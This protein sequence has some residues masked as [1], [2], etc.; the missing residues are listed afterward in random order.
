MPF[1]VPLPLRRVQATI[2]GA[3]ETE[4]ESMRIFGRT[5]TASGKQAKA[6]SGTKRLLTTAAAV[7]VA[8]A[9]VAVG[10]LAAL[11]AGSGVRA[12]DASVY[13]AKAA[14][15]Y[16]TIPD[17]LGLAADEAAGA[18]AGKP[19]TY[20]GTTTVGYGGIIGYEQ[21]LSVSLPGTVTLSDAKGWSHDIEATTSAQIVTRANQDNVLAGGEENAQ[22]SVEADP[23]LWSG[24]AEFSISVEGTPGPTAFAVFSNDDE[25]LSMYKRMVPPKEGSTYSVSG[26]KADGVYTNFERA[27][28]YESESSVPWQAWKAQMDHVEVIDGDGDDPKIAVE[29]M[30][31]WFKGCGSI[32]YVTGLEKLDVSGMTGMSRTFQGCASLTQISGM[33]GWNTKSLTTLYRTFSDCVAL[34]SLDLTGWDVT[35]VYSLY[36]TFYNCYSL[37]SVGDLSAWNTHL[38]RDASCAFYNCA[39]LDSIGDIS[40]WRVKRVGEAQGMFQ[41][42]YALTTLGD[43]SSWDTSALENASYMF[44]ACC[45][46]TDIGSLS[47]WN[48]DHLSNASNMFYCCENLTS[49]DLSG[50]S[51]KSCAN[52]SGMFRDDSSLASVGDISRWQTG[53]ITSSEYAFYNCRSLVDLGDLSGWDMGANKTARSMFHNCVEL[54][55]VGTLANW[56]C[57]ACETFEDMFNTCVKLD[58][59]DLRAWSTGAAAS[60][61]SM[62][63][64][65]RALTSTGDLDNWDMTADADASRMFYNCKALANVGDL[66][67]WMTPACTTFYRTFS[68]CAVLRSVGDLSGWDTSA[69]T[70]FD[71]F[72]QGCNKLDGL[73]NL[74]GWQTGSVRNMHSMFDGC[75]ELS[76]I[77]AADGSGGIGSWNLSSCTDLGSMFY[78]CYVIDAIGDLT[79]WDVSKVTDFGGMFFGC[80]NLP[81]L[82]DLSS[83]QV[84]AH[85]GSLE[86]QRM[87]CLCKKL[88]SIGH[89]EGW[90]VSKATSLNRLFGDCREITELGNLSQWDV[91]NC[92]NLTR[93]FS[94]CF[95][96]EDIGDISGW[97]TAKV[98]TMEWLFSGCYKLKAECV[99]GIGAWNVA[100][101]ENMEQMFDECDQL[102]ELDLSGWGASG[103]TPSLRNAA[104]MFWGNSNLAVLDISALDT[105]NVYAGQVDEWTTYSGMA[106]MFG[107]MP[108][109]EK[110]TLGD[111]FSFTGDGSS[112]CT[113]PGEYWKNTAGTILAVDAIP[114]HVADTYTKCAVQRTVAYEW[115]GSGAEASGWSCTATR[116]TKIDGA[117]H[118]D[119]EPTLTVDGAV[120]RTDDGSD[121]S[122]AVMEAV[123][124]EDWASTQVRR[125]LTGSVTID[126]VTPQAV[127]TLTATAAMPSDSTPSYRWYR[128]GAAIAGA[129][130]ST[131]TTTGDD[132]G[133]ALSVVVS[134]SSGRYVGSI[135]SSASASVA[136]KTW[137][138][139][140]VTITGGSSVGSTLTASVS[141]LP[142]S[143]ENTIK[144]QWY[145]RDSFASESTPFTVISGATSSTYKTASAD[146]GY[147]IRCIVTVANTCYDVNSATSNVIGCDYTS[148]G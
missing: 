104:K 85:G 111:A 62:F 60:T 115:S 89:L 128:D 55:N 114:S 41:Q 78:E 6:K 29:D 95:K 106:D 24:V 34:Q 48:T 69:A 92:E 79:S 134:D 103:G 46:L 20:T 11:A 138:S 38:V 96:L 90:D 117:V 109:L 133:C 10:G 70:H 64:D 71:Y 76:G 32:R 135:S 49:L 83:W 51:M 14:N 131:Y 94:G 107:A 25:S 141:G 27:E 66:S 73:G 119:I 148:L 65:C 80:E 28:L 113:L 137:T 86:I 127:Q 13:E 12:L 9:M 37:N 56:G 75:Y 5:A 43:L 129:T 68:G 61:A 7:G 98:G 101:V 120:T 124:A 45:A 126:D 99:A 26:K 100:S 44:A 88:E 122:F 30:S 42:C 19:G 93:T 21:T 105:T 139:L 35:D 58:G 82:G 87:F 52:M 63:Y 16:V 50:W 47:G 31:Y 54:S 8:A 140:S 59:L 36:N 102:T 116:T 136:K 39:V 143:G 112:S 121:A 3:S 84:G 91:S 17:S 2:R 57:G 144:Y 97:D 145:R 146:W 53:A 22:V 40:G 81:T 33:E 147:N 4:D 123:F 67:G 125:L 108:S 142:T 110:V 15:W 23:G 72:F 74:S 1:R 132:V 18:E 77:A 130:G 118:E